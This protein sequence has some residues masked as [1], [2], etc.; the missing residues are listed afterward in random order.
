MMSIISRRLSGRFFSAFSSTF[1]TLT[2]SISLAFFCFCWNRSTL[3]KVSTYFISPV[4]NGWHLLQISTWISCMVLPT[5][6]VFPQTQITLAS[7]KYCG[8]IF[9]FTVEYFNKK[10][11]FIQALRLI[12]QDRRK[13]RLL[14]FL[15]WRTYRLIC[16]SVRRSR[17]TNFLDHYLVL[18]QKLLRC[19]NQGLVPE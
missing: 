18:V 8:W 17:L 16:R 14:K 1:L 6:K 19:N 3:P 12:D 2:T 5:L 11:L 15:F 9:A 10:R 13:S 7:S 4:K